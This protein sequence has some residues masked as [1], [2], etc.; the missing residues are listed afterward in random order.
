MTWHIIR[1]PAGR[2]GRALSFWWLLLLL[3]AFGAGCGSS[4]SKTNLALTA[5]EAGAT[6]TPADDTDPDKAGVQYEVTG[7]SKG[8]TQGNTVYLFIDDVKQALSARVGSDGAIS[9]PDVTLDPGTHH[10]YLQTSTGSTTSDKDQTYTLQALEITSPDNGKTLKTIDDDQDPKTSGLQI[11][12]A[13]T[14]YALDLSQDINLLVDNKD[15]GTEQPDARGNAVFKGVTLSTG[16]HTLLAFTGSGDMRIDSAEVHVEVVQNC[17]AVNFI[18]PAPASDAKPITLGGAGNCPANTADP[19][20][21]TIRFSTDAGD[22]RTARLKVNDQP[23]S[24]ATVQGATV[25]FQDVVLDKRSGPNQIEVEVENADGEICPVTFPGGILVDC[26]GADCSITNPTPVTFVDADNNQTLYLNHSMVSDGGNGFDVEVTT[27][28]DLDG[29]KVQLI[30]DGNS[31]DPL[32]AEA[33]TSGDSATAL[34]SAV[35]LADG[36]HTLQ[37]Q[38]TDLAGNVTRSAK[39][40]WTADT[41]AC[42][43][44]ITDPAKDTVFVPADDTDGASDGTQVISTAT[45]TGN[46]CI[47]Q[48]AATCTPSAGIKGPNFLSYDG[49]SPL[50]STIT[51]DD[52]QAMQDLCVEV[53]DRAGNT[54][55]DSVAVTYRQDAPVVAI[56]SPA[57]GTKYNAQGGTGYVMDADRTNSPTA[58]DAAFSVSCSE[59]GVDVEL[60]HDSAT[61]DVFA[62]APCN[63]GHASVT[64]PF[65]DGDDTAV[66]VA[67]QSVMGASSQVLVGDSTPITL[68]G[69]CRPPA[70]VLSDACGSGSGNQLTTAQAAARDV[71]VTDSTNDT[72]SSTLTVVNGSTTEMLTPDT[73]TVTQA[74]YP[75]VDLGGLGMVTV[76]ATM[77]DNFANTTTAMCTATVIADLPT[78]TVSSPANDAV[79]GAGD[80]CDAGAGYGIALSAMA[81]QQGNRTARVV[82]NSGS[83]IDL[84][85]SIG[86][87]GAISACVPVPSQGPSSLVV[88]VSSTAGGGFAEAT[89]NIMVVGPAPG[90]GTGIT[91]DALPAVSPTGAGYR[92]GV[93]ATWTKPTEEY[94]GQLVA[95]EL[96]C[97]DTAIAMSATDSAKQTWWTGA[98]AVMLPSGLHPESAA[99]GSGKQSAILDFRPAEQRH[100]VLRA[101]DAL[102]QQTPI[103]QSTDLTL[104]FR[105]L[106]LTSGSTAVWLGSQVA[107]VGDVDGD[108]L[109]DVL[110]GGRGRA[111]LIFG[112]SGD[113]SA[114]A[115]VIFIGAGGT[116][117]GRAV[118][119]IGDFN[120]DGLDDFAI[121]DP[122]WNSSA[123]RVS[124][125]FG[126]PRNQWP[127]TAQDIETTCS[128]DLCLQGTGTNSIGRVLK[129]VGNFDGNGN[130]DFAVGSPYYPDVNSAPYSGQVLVVLGASYEKRACSSGSECRS[131][132]NCPSGGG[133]C[134]LNNGETFWKLQFEASSGDWLNPPSGGPVPKLNGFR[135]DGSG[136]LA[137]SQLGISFAAPGTF[138]AVPGADLVIGANKVGQVHYLSGRAHS[139]TTGFDVLT[140]SDLGLPGQ[141]GGTAIATGSAAA[142]FGSSIACTANLYN[143]STQTDVPDLAISESL[144]DQM[145]VQPGDGSPA[146]SS[147]RI[148]IQGP[149]SN[150]G[151]SLAS[152]VNGFQGAVGDLDLD[153]NGDLL[154]GTRTSSPR[155]VVL[156]YSDRF[157]SSVSSGT[158]QKSSG[159]SIPIAA[160]VASSAEFIVQYIGDMNGDGSPDAVVG[161]PRANSNNGQVILLY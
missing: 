154:V 107:A 109:E 116:G 47:E 61:G 23:M 81:D 139:G 3:G 45:I 46:D 8:L 33:S 145:Y 2:G 21:T 95:Y 140:V 13:V 146:F 44:D 63:S 68:R 18:S 58:C 150:I 142:F 6:L 155:D 124:V 79:F 9:L 83:P 73:L 143:P 60:H 22:G 15:A 74:S 148:T 54:G 25:T 147:A 65:E 26:S 110:V 69:D 37:A 52:S 28:K 39:L 119:G 30:V 50:M 67:T 93:P 133:F 138:D 57:D 27:D 85:S 125:F 158:V 108:G 144:S 12:V 153:G 152:S 99:D 16:K 130:A 7:T 59:N 71:T 49:T 43:V 36:A 20:T 156:W 1:K 135:L 141:P 31:Q 56:D 105:Q 4:G 161:D 113:L 35:D 97:A 5:P 96:R 128:A 102:G 122:F 92:G 66:V 98:T 106:V 87:G 41:A 121:G 72:A 94:T 103:V 55:R 89:R 24:T 100:C 104:K 64:A 111:E 51:L 62:H 129:A 127:S 91:I 160:A 137:D 112:T 77:T 70:A 132:E 29:H 159:I 19:F 11:D 48:R 32:E 126:R 78:L 53:Q 131:N 88:R 80:D 75:A 134:A 82:V 149:G 90:S 101:S 120:G 117:P 86:S 136:A 76:T 38:C 157:G 151:Y 118:G 114:A 123:G 17:A 34:F 115:K 42:G 10:I 84:T 40:K 14:A